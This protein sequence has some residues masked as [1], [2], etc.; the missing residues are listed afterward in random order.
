M[1]SRGRTVF[2]IGDPSDYLE[3]EPECVVCGWDVTERGWVKSQDAPD[4]SP[5][6]WLCDDCLD[7]K[8]SLDWKGWQLQRVML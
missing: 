2:L 8:P 5:T 3:G 1:A 6:Y 4:I 7:R